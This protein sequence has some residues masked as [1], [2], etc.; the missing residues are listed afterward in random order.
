MKN[1]KIREVVRYSRREAVDSFYSNY[2]RCYMSPRRDQTVG[3][4]D[5][6]IVDFINGGILTGVDG[7]E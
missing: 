7:C 6:G 5:T 1:I 2:I 4:L 3:V